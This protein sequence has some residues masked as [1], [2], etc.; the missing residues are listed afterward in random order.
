[1]WTRQVPL[2]EK[3]PIKEI[4]QVTR[5]LHSASC[6][7]SSL[8]FSNLCTQTSQHHTRVTSLSILEFT[9]YSLFIIIHPFINPSSIL[10]SCSSIICTAPL[11]RWKQPERV[12]CRTVD[13]NHGIQS[14][15]GC[16][17]ASKK[18]RRL[19]WVLYSCYGGVL[20]WI[21]SECI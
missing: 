2:E 17:W 19:P 11:N 18:R 21:F 1:M 20:W 7:F 6:Q 16:S 8:F 3:T 4:P 9:I 10:Q 15:G 5:P 14:T 12:D 13:L